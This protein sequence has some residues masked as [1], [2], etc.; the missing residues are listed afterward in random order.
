VLKVLK[1]LA[2]W[3]TSPMDRPT[4]E[5]RDV[6]HS[7]TKPQDCANRSGRLF[8]QADERPSDLTECRDDVQSMST[9][10]ST[11][12]WQLIQ[13]QH[14][15]DALVVKLARMGPA[16]RNLATDLA[17]SRRD[18]RAK[19]Q[20]IGSL[21]AENSR[22]R[23]VRP[24]VN[25]NDAP[26]P[27]PLEACVSTR[28]QAPARH[29]E[30]IVDR[31]RRRI[32]R[33]LHDGAQ[34]RLVAL[35]IHLTLAEDFVRA[36][37]ERGVDR[38]RALGKE[39]E[40]ILEE[41]RSLAR[42]IYPSQ[43][44]RLGPAEALR[45]AARRSPLVTSVKSDGIGRHAPEVESALYFT[46]LEALQN[47]SKHA[48]GARHVTVSLTEDSHLRFVVKDDG[49]GFDVGAVAPG[50]GMTNMRDRLAAV[51]GRIEI[52][53]TLGRG[54]IVSGHLPLHVLRRCGHPRSG[55]ASVSPVWDETPAR[56]SAGT[57]RG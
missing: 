4:A 30:T 42:G 50:S 9:G 31:E 43:L 39:V 28:S 49:A 56:A 17:A 21:R 12:R 15:N 7:R 54:T 46:V 8:D 37:P 32:E 47:A 52:V 6:P 25:R 19:E 34:Q 16:I 35:R 36:D 57:Q 18:L 1:L 44:L 33:D 24:E 55:S 13:L 41:I 38:L 26:D 40:A 3:G 48:S 22:L 10:D 29:R 53:S 51:G 20:Q 2:R 5:G 45:E 23:S 14:E 27:Q 11:T